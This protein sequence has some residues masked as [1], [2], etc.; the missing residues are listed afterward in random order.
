[1]WRKIKKNHSD[2]L[3]KYITMSIIRSSDDGG[4][5]MNESDL[6]RGTGRRKYTLVEYILLHFLPTQYCHS[7]ISREKKKNQTQTNK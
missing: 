3:K 2:T 1:M 7:F 4:G 5:V 6:G